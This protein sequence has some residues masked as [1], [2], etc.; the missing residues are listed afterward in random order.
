M[1]VMGVEA[2]R[3][4]VE[5]ALFMWRCLTPSGEGFDLSPFR[6]SEV[7]YSTLMQLDDE[8]F[9]AFL[10]ACDKLLEEINSS[11][12]R[13]ENLKLAHLRDYR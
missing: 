5:V 4:Q 9:N 12:Q 6:L 7:S 13:L 8:T 11:P 10:N 3:R 1:G 2:R